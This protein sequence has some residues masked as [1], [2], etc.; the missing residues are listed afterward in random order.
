MSGRPTRSLPETSGIT[1][2]GFQTFGFVWNLEGKCKVAKSADIPEANVPVQS[3]KVPSSHE[4]ACMQQEITRAAQVH[5]HAEAFTEAY[6]KGSTTAPLN[7]YAKRYLGI[8]RISARTHATEAQRATESHRDQT[9]S[10][11]PHHAERCEAI[12][13]CRYLK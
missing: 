10:T 2:K 3:P 9:L 12:S 1:L 6:R 7:S 5:K 4:Q 13:H 11:L 8:A